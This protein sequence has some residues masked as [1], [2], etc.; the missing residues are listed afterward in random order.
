MLEEKKT[1]DTVQE[2]R[3]ESDLVEERA[4]YANESGGLSAIM[5]KIGA[6]TNVFPDEKEA[7]SSVQDLLAEGANEMF[8]QALVARAA[9]LVK[10]SL[11]MDALT[12]SGRMEWKEVAPLAQGH[13]DK[14]VEYIENNLF[15][16]EMDLAPYA[17]PDEILSICKHVNDQLSEFNLS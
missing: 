8:K 1:Y 9:I 11:T 15:L 17:S 10:F 2:F 3:K 13:S 4:K 6:K 16:S 12:L 14:L 5:G 7:L